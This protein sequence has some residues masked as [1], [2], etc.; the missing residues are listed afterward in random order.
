MT[1]LLRDKNGNISTRHEMIKKKERKKHKNWSNVLA[2]VMSH[3]RQDFQ[4]CSETDEPQEF[5]V[6]SYLLTIEFRAGV[7]SSPSQLTPTYV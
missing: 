1:T 3:V 6:L 7:S 5:P 4:N 2:I